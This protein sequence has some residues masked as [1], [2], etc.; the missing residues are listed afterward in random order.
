[1]LPPKC[2]K[3]ILRAATEAPLIYWSTKQIRLKGIGIAEDYCASG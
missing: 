2:Q 3:S 1:M